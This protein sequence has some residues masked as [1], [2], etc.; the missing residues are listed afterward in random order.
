MI[1][2]YSD[3]ITI[4]SINEFRFY[5]YKGELLAFYVPV[6]NR[7]YIEGKD[8]K[9]KSLIEAMESTYMYQ[10]KGASITEC[11]SLNNMLSNINYKLEF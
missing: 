1:N 4:V 3:K 8:M 7:F 10:Y 2:K 9:K 6:L 11:F 5:Y